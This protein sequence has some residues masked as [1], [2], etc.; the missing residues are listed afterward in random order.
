[1]TETTGGGLT[2]EDVV[3]PF[4]GLGCDDVKLTVK[5]DAVEAGEGVCGRA[6]ALF[7]RGPEPA[8]SARVNGREVPLE[9]A[10]AAAAELLTTAL[11]P[12]YAGLGADVD[13]VRSVIRLAAKTGGTV[14]HYASDG[15]YKNLASSQ[16]KGWIATTFAEVRNRCDLFVVVGPD[17]SKAFHQLYARVTPKTGRF[18]DGARKI[19]FLGG[20]PSAEARAQLEGA[21][22]E[23]IAVPEGGLVDALSRLQALVGG[24]TPPP[25]EP[26]LA[27]LAAA[28]KASKYAVLAWS[29]SS[30]G[31]DGDL[32]IERAVSV[33]AELNVGTRAACLPLSGKDNLTGAYHVSL[34][35]TGFPLRLGL[36][37]GVSSHDQSAY[38]TANSL[39]D[40]DVVVWTSAFRPEKPPAAEAPLIAIAHPA[41]E[42][43]REPDVFIPVGQPGLDHAG[44]VFRADSVVGLPLKKYR[45][46][47]LKSVAEIVTSIAEAQP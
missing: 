43:E 39:G 25:A 20:E 19:V 32:V 7:R 8:P 31:E 22:V 16:R 35:T 23:T 14:D 13:G 4:C 15:L 42:F 10:V 37:G 9:A 1:M 11:S 24:Q 38:S 41:T 6:A 30:L 44:L 46:A 33:V 5:G 40:A 28:L 45:D 12:V 26:D 29:A 47:G 34:W 3:C 27:P 2:H 21:I 17:P 36:R 18:L